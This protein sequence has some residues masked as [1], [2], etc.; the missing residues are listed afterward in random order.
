MDRA[1]RDSGGT[2]PAF[3]TSGSRPR[4][5]WTTPEAKSRPSSGLTPR[6]SSSPRGDRRGQLRDSRSCRSARTHRTTPPDRQRYR[7]RS[8]A[9]HAQG[10]CAPGWR[11][12]LLPVDHSGVLNPDALRDAITPDTA[13]VSVMHANNEIGTIQPVAEIA[14]IAKAHGALV[15]TDAVQTA[16]K[17]P[18]DVKALGWICCRSRVTSST[19]RKAS[20]PCGSERRSGCSCS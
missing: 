5:A 12:T 8:S 3:T 9:Q 17:V 13:L 6:K 2:P 11:V 10:A 19:D 4:R 15:H 7:A 16:G 20:A 1:V 14:A 18:I